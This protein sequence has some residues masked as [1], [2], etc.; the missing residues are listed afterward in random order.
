MAVRSVLQGIRVG[1]PPSHGTRDSYATYIHIVEDLAFAI[2]ELLLEGLPD[3]FEIGS[4]V[5]TYRTS[6]ADSERRLA[7]L[8]AS[9][10][11]QH[12]ANVPQLVSHVQH[13]DPRTKSAL[14]AGPVAISL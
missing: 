5:D 10:V 6:D 1:S 2:L 8:A 13:S 3:L 12:Q 9:T 14:T 4:A 7:M 11:A